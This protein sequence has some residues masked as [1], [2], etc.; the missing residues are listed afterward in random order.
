MAAECRGRNGR[1]ST[2]VP[3]LFGRASQAR[4]PR[5]GTTTRRSRQIRVVLVAAVLVGGA[6]GCTPGPTQP[7]PSGQASV[8]L[9]TAGRSTESPAAGRSS[10]P[11]PMQVG[12]HLQHVPDANVLHGDVSRPRVVA[13]PGGGFLLYMREDLPNGGRLFGSDDGT[14]WTPLGARQLPPI[15]RLS[16]IAATSTAVVAIGQDLPP[17]AGGAEPNIHAF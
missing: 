6:T 16:D 7:P 3:P 17:D 1:L 4:Q 10:Q 15:P 9:E 14:V 8:N 12:L 5:G 2:R 13:L 11:D